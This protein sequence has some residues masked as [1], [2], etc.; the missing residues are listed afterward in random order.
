MRA[1]GI[2]G[3]SG[4]RMLG[5]AGLVCLAT[6][7]P[8]ATPARADAGFGGFR[9]GSRIVRDG[10][11]EDDVAKKCGDPDAVRTWTEYRSEAIWEA[12][13]KIERSIPIQY[14]EWKFDFGTGRL[15]HYATFVQGRLTSVR[16]G[17]YGR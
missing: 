16:T 8:A 1:S 5:A 14:D 15:I 6:L 10:D 3:M 17:S 13:R 11:T 2:S 4:M 12:G 9:C 7:G